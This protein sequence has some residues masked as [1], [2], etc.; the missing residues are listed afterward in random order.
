MDFSEPVSFWDH[1]SG[2]KIFVFWTHLFVSKSYG[3]SM[4]AFE[5]AYREW[6]LQLSLTEIEFLHQVLKAS[7]HL[8]NVSGIPFVKAIQL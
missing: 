3:S 5:I 8:P 7:H 6:Q 1:E 2:T 4:L